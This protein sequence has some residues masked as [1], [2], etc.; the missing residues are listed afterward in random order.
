MTEYKSKTGTVSKSPFELYMTFVDMRNFSQM[1]PKD[2][3]DMVEADY[4]TI[5][6]N[7]QGY[8]IGAKV[9]T[10][11]PYSLIE[12]VDYGAPF[13]FKVSLNF[14]SAG[15]GDKCQFSIDFAADLNFMM[16]MM[17]GNKIK[18]A[19]D[20]VVD[21]LV[22]VSEGRMPEGVDPSMMEQF[23]NGFPNNQ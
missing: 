2:K 5:K 3:R 8:S 20:K 9:F 19:L 15:P 18:D 22:A 23:K 17:I 13:A 11:T 4:D 12:L 16:K 14:N 21:G 10:R 7:V 6:V 1:L